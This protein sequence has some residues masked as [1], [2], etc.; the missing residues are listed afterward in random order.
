MKFTRLW[1][2]IVG[3]VRSFYAGGILLSDVK[4]C[5]A[6]RRVVRNGNNVRRDKARCSSI[7]NTEYTV[8][9][10]VTRAPRSVTAI[11]KERRQANFA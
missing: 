7:D 2:K 10:S 11:R 8:S 9:V 1:S 6:Y 3:F 5:D 4:A